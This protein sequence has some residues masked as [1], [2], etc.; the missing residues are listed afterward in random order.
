M[1]FHIYGGTGWVGNSYDRPW[2]WRAT[3]ANGKIMADSAESYSSKAKARRAVRRFVE[4]LG[5]T[6]FEIVELD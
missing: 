2:Y 3:A 4:L 5:A 1:K 6:S